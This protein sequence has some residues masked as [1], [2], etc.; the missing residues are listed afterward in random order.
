MPGPAIPAAAGRGHPV[1]VGA[2][3]A[4]VVAGGA[5]V[6]VAEQGGLGGL[7][8]AGLGAGRWMRSVTRTSK[9]TRSLTR[10]CMFLS[11]LKSRNNVGKRS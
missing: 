1:V 6:V 9:P 8:G 2:L 5:A 11:I 10:T 3:G 7:G 4:A